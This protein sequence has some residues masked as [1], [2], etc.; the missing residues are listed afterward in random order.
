MARKVPSTLRS[1]YG[2]QRRPAL[3]SWPQRLL[4]CHC[5]QLNAYFGQMVRIIAS[6]GGDIFKF[7]GDAM[8]GALCGVLVRVCCWP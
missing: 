4:C 5:V 7:A 6:E 3:G 1:M 2:A 8:I